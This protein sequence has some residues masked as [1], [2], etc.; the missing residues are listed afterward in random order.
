MDHLKPRE[1][2]SI[3]MAYTEQGF[4]E[5]DSSPDFLLCFEKQFRSKFD[6]MNS[7][8]ISKY[9]FCFTQNGFKG[10]GTFYRYLQKSLTKTIKTFDTGNIRHMFIEFNNDQN[11]LNSGIKGRIKD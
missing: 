3:L 9:Y 8:D 6:M 5:N 11:R 1:L 2:T 4:F 7:E 10:D